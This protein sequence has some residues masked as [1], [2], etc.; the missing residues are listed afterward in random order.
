MENQFSWAWVDVSTYDSYLVELT[1][2]TSDL[3]GR[4]PKYA[5]SVDILIERRKRRKGGRGDGKRRENARKNKI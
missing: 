3:R 5:S 4:A 1:Y 2:R